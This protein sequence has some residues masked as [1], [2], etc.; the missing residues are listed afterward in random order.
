M[1]K[2]TNQKIIFTSTGVVVIVSVVAIALLVVLSKGVECVSP[3][4]GKDISLFEIDSHDYESREYREYC[5]AVAKIEDQAKQLREQYRVDEWNAKR[6]ALNAEYK[7][8]GKALEAEYKLKQYRDEL[9]VLHTEYE[10][11]KQESV[12]EKE[13]NAL[14]NEQV[15]KEDA[16]HAEYNLGAF[17]DAYDALDLEY[18]DARD[19]QNAEHNISAFHDAIKKLIDEAYID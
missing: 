14:D 1:K 8:N 4:T 18:Y 19:A 10:N 15:A 7:A 17:Q 2:L 5:N 11:K 16:L 9:S 3:Y 6:D 13:W 12:T